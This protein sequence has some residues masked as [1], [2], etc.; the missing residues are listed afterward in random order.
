MSEINVTCVISFHSMLSA[1]DTAQKVSLESCIF[2]YIDTFIVSKSITLI[3]C[4]ADCHNLTLT[5]NPAN[6]RYTL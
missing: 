1:G 5:T 2:V 3:Q 6:G 4:Q